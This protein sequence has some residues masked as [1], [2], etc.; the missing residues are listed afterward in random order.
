MRQ[1]FSAI[2][3]LNNEVNLR[4]EGTAYRGVTFP[5]KIKEPK[6][7]VNNPV[8]PPCM[9]A[10]NHMK[11]ISSAVVS[12]MNL[13]LETLEPGITDRDTAPKPCLRGLV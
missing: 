6:T 8:Y 13:G 5:N 12:G 9:P 11:H 4:C 7:C 1:P 2:D 3:C 10:N